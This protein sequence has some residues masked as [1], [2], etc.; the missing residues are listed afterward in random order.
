[1]ELCT[2]HWRSPILANVDAQVVGISRGTPRWSL[3]FKYR[4][5][6][7]LAPQTLA[8]GR[9]RTRNSLKRATP[10]S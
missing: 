9:R 4:K 3:P 5:L 7:A 2:S 1:M 10:S 8:P 6:P